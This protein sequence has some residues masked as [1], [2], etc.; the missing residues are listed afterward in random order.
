MKSRL[1]FCGLQSGFHEL[2][3]GIFLICYQA[4]WPFMTY[5]FLKRQHR[6]GKHKGKLTDSNLFSKKVN[7][8]SSY[9]SRKQSVIKTIT[10]CF[11]AGALGLEPRAY[12][13][14]DRRSTN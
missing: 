4:P 7:L 11:L 12:G 1:P 3:Y 8:K 2:S 14:G 5:V 9:K 13:F 6:K 10:D